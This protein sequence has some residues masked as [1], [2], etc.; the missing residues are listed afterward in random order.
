MSLAEDAEERGRRS[1]PRLFVLH[2]AALQRLAVYIACTTLALAI[3]Y[4]IGKEMAW[5]TLNYHL[6]AGFSAIHDRFAQDY[7]A[8]GPASYLNPFAFVPFYALVASGLPAIAVASVLA[9]LQSV[10]LWLT[11]ELGLVVSPSGSAARRASFATCSVA[12]AALNP[13][14]L[15]QLGSSFS[16]ITT[17]ELV[18]GGWLLLATAVRAPGAPRIIGAAVLLGAATALKLTNAVH[19]VSAAA[20]LLFLPVPFTRRFRLATAYVI[21][22][23]LSFAC[24]EAPWAYR[25]ENRFGNPLFPLLNTVFRSPEFTT[26]PLRHFR[27]IPSSLGEAL[28]RPF[29]MLDP[30]TMIHMEMRAPDLRYAVLVVLT[31]GLA[32]DWLRRRFATS[33]ESGRA[34]SLVEE[35]VLAALGCG[36]AV[37]WF[38][39]LFMSGNSRYFLPM[40]CV[41]GVLLIGLLFKLF[42]AQPKL[43]NYVLTALFAAQSLQLWVGTDFRWNGVPWNGGKWFEIDVP[44]PLATSPALYLTMGFQSN[45]FVLPYLSPGAGLIDFSGAYPLEASGANGEHVRAL[46]RSY[47]PHLRSL[48]EQE[49]P[50]ISDVNGALE[51]FGLRVEPSDCATIV[52]HH[53]P[54]MA[55]PTFAGSPR[56]ADR[57][58]KPRA[59]TSHLVSCGLVPYPDSDSHSAEMARQQAVADAVFD[60]LEDACPAL[61]QPRRVPTDMR[62]NTA[63][64]FYMNTDLTAW[65]ANGSVQ[66]A[67]PVH[68][69]YVVG[70]GRASDWQ[71]GSPRLEC[72]RRDGRY[73]AGLLGRAGD[74]GGPTASQ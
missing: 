24:L 4:A 13:V 27:F 31:C 53:L 2:A 48:A 54:V 63:W 39:W 45:S 14:L 41:G 44:S 28:W 6:Y 8:A 47:A 25:L 7:F 1:T 32:M 3:N 66:F 15:Q 35:R 10:M 23:A 72:G 43:R 68:G 71:K 61:F 70:L 60:R 74:T 56:G 64:R 16:D 36:F 33:G 5:D 21:A 38:A 9:A 50:R 65:I 20:V 62:G 49:T 51:R 30:G 26:E 55:E 17:G 69:N 18:L 46:I 40:A 12:M 58:F 11:F 29:A 59:Q 67:D 34:D 73:S 57:V 42:A 52:V 19:A 22:L 37:D